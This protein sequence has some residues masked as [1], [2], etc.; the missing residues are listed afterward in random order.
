MRNQKC[1]QCGIVNFADSGSCRRCGYFFSA[2][3]PRIE[4]TPPIVERTRSLPRRAFAIIGVV[5]AIV[6][7]ARASLTLTSDGLDATQQQSVAAAVDLL[8]AR[9]FSREVF[10]LDRVANYRASDNWWNEYVGHS[11]AY[12]ATNFP[13]EV[14]TLYPKFFRVPIDDTERAFILFHEAQHLLGH[15]EDVAL[16]TAW[17]AKTGIGWSGVKYEGTRL[18]RN[19]REWTLQSAPLLFKCGEDGMSDCVE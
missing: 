14:V 1:P 5:L 9:G 19:T 6:V 8:R 15:G 18:W 3:Q 11:D 7:A 2:P 13:F 17:M 4:G 10:V 16:Q 12:A